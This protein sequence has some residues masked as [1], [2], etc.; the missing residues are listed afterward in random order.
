MYRG[1]MVRLIDDNKV[2]VYKE[3]YDVDKD[4]KGQKLAMNQHPVSEELLEDKTEL[5]MGLIIKPSSGVTI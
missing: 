4:L 5:L 1:E 3:I 2:Q